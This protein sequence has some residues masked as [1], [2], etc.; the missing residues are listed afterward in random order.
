[1]VEKKARQGSKMPPKFQKGDRVK[2]YATRF[3]KKDKDLDD[4]E[5]LFSEKWTAD[6]NGIWCH[7]AVSR[8]HVKKGRRPQE[9]MIRYDNGESMRGI[10]EHLEASQDDGE[11]EVASEEGK[12][13]MDR[14]S[15]ECS[16]D[17]EIDAG[18]R[19]QREDVDREVT[20]DEAGEVAEG[21]E[22]EMGVETEIGETVTKGNEDDPKKKTWTRIPSMPTSAWTE[23][24][25]NGLVRKTTNKKAAYFGSMCMF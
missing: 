8:V 1:V 22:G 10:E 18:E 24:R 14:D 3:D 17:P 4:G 6:G 23:C 15:D 12:D 25:M 21:E 2:A 5:Q 19:D 13:N 16:T 7:G 20:D 9:Y 11:S